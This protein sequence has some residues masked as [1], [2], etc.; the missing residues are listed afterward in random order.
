MTFIPYVLVLL[1]GVLNAIRSAINAEL[2]ITLEHPWWAG[3]F[4]CPISGAFLLL[5]VRYDCESFPSES[6]FG[7]THWWASLGTA[8]PVISTLFLAGRLT[9]FAYV[10]KH[11]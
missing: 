10:S 2:N 9:V 3:E 8:I 1:T 4:V 6:G 11:H 5:G 7:A